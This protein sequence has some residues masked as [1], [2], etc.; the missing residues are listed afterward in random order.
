[1]L[2]LCYIYEK[3]SACRDVDDSIRGYLKKISCTDDL[4]LRC[5]GMFPP[6][7]LASPNI[8]I[9]P[10][11]VY[12]VTPHELIFRPLMIFK[13]EFLRRS[14]DL[15]PNDGNAATPS[16]RGSFEA[17]AQIFIVSRMS[18]CRM[19]SCTTRGCAPLKT[20]LVP[21]VTRSA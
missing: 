13:V 7:I 21:N 2:S 4:D 17:S 20:R 15:H 12:G 3:L 9:G 8:I 18:L 11:G 10:K 19:S 6:V 16:A 14:G 1:M 5:H